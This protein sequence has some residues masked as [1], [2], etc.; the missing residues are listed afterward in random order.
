MKK[1]LI[2]FFLAICSHFLYSKENRLSLGIGAGA[3]NINNFFRS[4]STIIPMPIIELKYDNF[5]ING[6]DFGYTMLNTDE[7][8][9]SL[10]VN[11]FDGYSLK[12]KDM[13]DGYKSIDSRKHQ[14]AGGVSLEYD[15][16]FY[17]LRTIASV[18]GGEYGAKGKLK[19]IKHFALT[20]RLHV[21]PSLGVNLYSKDY[22]DYYWGIDKDE[23][24]KKITREYNPDFGYSGTLELAAEYYLNERLTVLAFM[25]AEKFS[26]EIG[27]SPIIDN[28]TLMKMG[29]GIRYSF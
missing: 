1:N 28:N 13:D 4:D 21:Y 2:I 19:V 12:S 8:A 10:F 29:A 16:D 14:I 7:L 25:S 22:T 20:D 9:F 18:S 23:L 27:N 6:F 15:M 24:G 17:D 26:S 3:T 11:P 5:Y